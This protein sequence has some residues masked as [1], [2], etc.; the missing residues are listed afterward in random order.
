MC[1]IFVFIGSSGSGKTEIRDRVSYVENRIVTTT[2][3]H[4]RHNEVDGVD[5]N[6][7]AKSKFDKAA[8]IEKDEKY[9]NYYGLEK[10]EVEEKFKNG[11]CFA[12]LTHSGYIELKKVYGEDVVGIFID[13]SLEDLNKML[14]GRG[15]EDISKR[16]STYKRD[17]DNID[18]YEY[19]VKNKYSKLQ[20]AIDKVESI[21]T[22]ESKYSSLR[23]F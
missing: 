8:L 19:V 10:K 7:V 5:Y 2:T 6:F 9:G 3:R 12:I 4:P 18:D 21:I 22:G 11:N 17:R 16:L 14:S 15:E 20:E 1:K 13:T 23:F